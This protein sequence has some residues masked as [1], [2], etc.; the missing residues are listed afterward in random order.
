MKYVTCTFKVLKNPD[1]SSASKWVVKYMYKQEFG[2][3]TVPQTFGTYLTR[4]EA[5]D[6]LVYHIGSVLG[7]LSNHYYDLPP[8]VEFRIDIN[9]DP[10]D[11]DIHP[12]N[13]TS[14]TNVRLDLTWKD[15]KSLDGSALLDLMYDILGN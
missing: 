4:G 12:L 9:F 3:A 13:H 5:M 2:L 14:L 8:D 11:P 15:D 7:D 1:V 10:I 6:S